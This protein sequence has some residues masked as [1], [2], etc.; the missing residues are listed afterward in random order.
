MS[1]LDKD[2]TFY[3]KIEDNPAVCTNC[4]RRLK[5]YSDPHYTLPDA[6]TRLVE[7]EN[8]VEHHWVDDKGNTERP[9]IKKPVCECGD[10]DGSK[11]RPLDNSELMDIARRIET[12]L[13][14]EDV[15]IDEDSFYSFIKSSR[16]G[17]DIHFNEEKFF[18]EAT[19]RSIID[20][21]NE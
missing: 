10:I 12:R 19:E 21:N 4:Y 9:S 11:I 8:H 7:Y 5:S 3:K 6:V 17:S 1:E 15:D 13:Y 16:D 2:S 14:E 20:K 18:E